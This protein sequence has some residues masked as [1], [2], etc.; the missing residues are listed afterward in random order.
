MCHIV[1]I[2]LPGL[3]QSTTTVNLLFSCLQAEQA[4]LISGQQ[5]SL[6]VGLSD[7]LLATRCKLYLAYSLLQ[8]GKLK[9]AN[10][11]IRFVQL[12]V[13]L[14]MFGD[15]SVP[16]KVCCSVVVLFCLIW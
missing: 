6:A 11:I 13:S 4:G 12:Q 2:L 5:L 3:I 10:K 15:V 8:R 7:P 1:I 14:N 9:Q 16:D